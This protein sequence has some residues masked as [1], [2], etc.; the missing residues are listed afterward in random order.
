L[1]F[2]I[3]LTFLFLT[4]TTNFLVMRTESKTDVVIIGAGIMSATIAMLL[5][6]LMPNVTIDIYE[7]LDSVAAESSDAWNNAGT[8]HSAFCELNYTPQKPDG[9]VDISKALKIA[10]AFELSRQFWSYLANKKY[11]ADPH[12]FINK[13]PHMS[14]V[15]GRDNVDYLKKRYEAL[16]P[17]PLFEGMKFSENTAELMEWIPLVMQGRDTS[18]PVAATRMERGTDID[19]GA[20]T[21]ALIERLKQTEGINLYL[22]H[23]VKDID[24][25]SRDEDDYTWEVFVKD[26][27]HNKK[28]KINANYVFI[29]AGG[30]SLHLLD[31]SGI[32]EGE[33]YGGFPV[34]GQWL[35]CTNR[36]VIEK[37]AAKVYGKPALGAPPM[38]VP[39][40]DTRIIN[41]KKELL[42]GPYA[43]FSGKFLKSG[44]IL[45]LPRSIEFSNLW[46]VIA[47]GIHNY[48]LTKY[49]I[50]QATQSQEHRI[51]ALREYFPEVKGEDWE[52]I[53]AGQRVQIIKKDDEE[54]GVLEF[55]TEIV[56][57]ADGSLSALLGASP[58]ASTS[59][60]VMLD[61]VK[62]AF[63]KQFE[64]EAWQQK[65]KEMIPA[66]GKSLDEDH[67]LCVHIRDYVEK[68]LGL[69]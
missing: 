57:S 49:L 17:H 65:L 51:E 50:M 53:V 33:G 30:G 8:G 12:S 13:N 23:E 6:E 56:S 40:L 38:S 16:A 67:D 66:F 55:G 44:S 15:W 43:G 39:H 5:K 20:L 28:K 46:P 18:Q 48:S 68:S 36:E 4:C 10:A 59:V 31:K 41:G 3:T 69:L 29:C 22:Q 35:R 52:L 7:R 1:L 27:V 64:S 21:R 47:V 63:P 2:N 9:S 11:I 14:F 54:G 24:P 25:D 61:M 19:F 37:H 60:A 45:D 58:G 34:S 62:K 42:F 26:T 32:H